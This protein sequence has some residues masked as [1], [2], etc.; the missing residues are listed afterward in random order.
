MSLSEGMNRALV[1]SI[2]VSWFDL[3]WVF[4]VCLEEDFFFLLVL[5]FS[6][7]SAF[8]VRRR[9]HSL[10][11]SLAHSPPSSSS[12]SSLLL[13]FSLPLP[14]FLFFNRFI[15]PGFLSLSDVSLSLLL[16]LF[17]FLFLLLFLRRF[18]KPAFEEEAEL[19]SC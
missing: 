15:N 6:G 4:L 17:L 11:R 16:L 18:M 7:S 19:E 5:P 1:S 3:V 8:R 13:L 10:T 2:N 9:A 12:S 14:F